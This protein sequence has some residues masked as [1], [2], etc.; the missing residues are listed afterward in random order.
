MT[1]EIAKRKSEVGNHTN[2]PQ[3]EASQDV[4][5]LS[6]QVFRVLGAGLAL[7]RMVQHLKTE[8]RHQ[9]RRMSLGRHLALFNLAHLDFN[10][11]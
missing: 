2:S 6:A 7:E 11:P 3:Q 5:W 9:G 8:Q 1:R 10:G 4:R